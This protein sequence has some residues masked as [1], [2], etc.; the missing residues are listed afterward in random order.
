MGRR[1]GRLGPDRPVRDEVGGRPNLLGGIKVVK[2]AGYTA[3]DDASVMIGATPYFTW[4]NRGGG[5]EG[6]DS[7]PTS[8]YRKGGR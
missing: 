5:H 8:R 7:A 4:A 2:A 1:P 3:T 6:L